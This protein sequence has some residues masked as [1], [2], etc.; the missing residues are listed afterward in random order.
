MSHFIDCLQSGLPPPVV[1]NSPYQVAPKRKMDYT[2]K[3]VVEKVKGKIGMVLFVLYV[4]LFGVQSVDFDITEP[5]TEYPFIGVDV[6][7]KD[8]K[9]KVKC[10]RYFAAS[11]QV[12]GVKIPSCINLD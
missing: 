7:V 6:L 12:W 3:G 5:T 10:A 8:K 1:P 11:K 2:V 9:G 4:C